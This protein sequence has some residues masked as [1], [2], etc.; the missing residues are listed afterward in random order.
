MSR[1]GKCPNCGGALVVDNFK[2]RSVCVYCGSEFSTAT[3][4]QKIV[5]DGIAGFDSLM[6]AAQRAIEYDHDH[7]KAAQK[8]RAALDIKP[9]DFRAVW[10]L[11]LCEAAAI[12][13][14]YDLHGYVKVP[15]DAESCIRRAAARYGERAIACAPDDEVRRYYRTYMDKETSR[16]ISRPQEKRG[17]YI[18]T[19]VYGSY[20]CPE[21]WTLRRYRDEKLMKSAFGRLFVKIYYALAPTVVKLFGKRAAFNA[22]WKKRLDKKVEKLNADGYSDEPY[23][24]GR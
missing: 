11:Y 1:E 15:N 21:V 13:H 16:Y 7:D 17:C 9:D 4:V 12:A 2:E 19:A 8:Y 10:G 3:A 24:D 18:A 22:F 5:I 23:F 14:A 6:L 20:D